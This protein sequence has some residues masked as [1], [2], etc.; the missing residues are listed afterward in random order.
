MITKIKK[1]SVAASLACIFSLAS[2]QAA[3]A[4]DIP[5][6]RVTDVSSQF[7]TTERVSANAVNGSGLSGGL[8]DQD[9]RNT[10]LMNGQINGEITFQLPQNYAVDNI[11]VWNYSEGLGE[12]GA[13]NVTISTST[14]DSG[15]FTSLGNFVFPLESGDSTPGFSVPG[16][17]SQANVRRIK[18]EMAGGQ[19]VANYGDGFA[20]GLNEVRFQTN[21]A[22]PT[23]PTPNNLI[24]GV[25]V[26]AV[27]SQ[28]TSPPRLA[29]NT[30]DGSGLSGVFPN[31]VHINAGDPSLGWMNDFGNFG[32]Q[33]T[34]T[35]NLGA[36]KNLGGIKIW[37]LMFG[38]DDYH[39][40]TQLNV[41]VSADNNT[42]SN[43]GDFTL[44]GR[45]PA[46]FG[47][48]TYPGNFLDL[49]TA[50]NLSLLNDIQYVRLKA[51]SAQADRPNG[52]TLITT[53]GGGNV[54]VGF[55]EVQFFDA[56][57]VPEPSTAALA[58]LGVVG[59]TMLGGRR[60]RR[61]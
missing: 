23:A 55:G 57:V 7:G 39:M 14:S 58:V 33:A 19:N 29:A 8:H 44:T 37:G 17:T 42:Y 26:Q 43:L 10:W 53:Q 45:N 46:V 54:A 3:S 56:V 48:T 9:P 59:L 50:T 1:L 21:S 4:V 6:V 15:A 60:R 24:N 52:D 5:N 12:R 61:A 38:T 49:S 36:L 51:L 13:K 41:E 22:I 47:A 11:R 2:L 16:W 32:Q 27:S 18:F 31:Q 25:S 34:I 28:M 30:V 35:Y 20:T 40:A